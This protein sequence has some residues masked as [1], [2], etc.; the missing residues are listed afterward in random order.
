MT[1]GHC[2]CGAVR[3]TI[4]DLPRD[5]GICHCKMCQ[6][7][8]GL[9]FAA[10]EVPDAQVT[11]EGEEHVSRYRSSD[12]STRSFCRI[13]GSTLWFR[14]DGRPSYEIPV[15][16]LDD[17]DHLR[18]THEIFVDRKPDGWGLA[19]DHPRETEQDYFRRK[20]HVPQPASRP[21]SPAEG[22]QP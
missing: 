16:L 22:G 6:R 19:G 14:D 10:I 15:G 4:T 5:F 3:V 13:C 12:I 18:L 9:A 8:T 7:W 21:A 2:L 1:T 17:A 20:G 11:V